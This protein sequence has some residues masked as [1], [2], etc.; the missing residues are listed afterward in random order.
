MSQ[1]LE[2]GLGVQVYT[3]LTET[4]LH[5]AAHDHLRPLHTP[6]HTC[7]IKDKSRDSGEDVVHPQL[8]K[9]KQHGTLTLKKYKR[10]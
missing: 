10:I 5:C 1:G 3:A 7:V 6:A 2:R 4:T 9:S 8:C